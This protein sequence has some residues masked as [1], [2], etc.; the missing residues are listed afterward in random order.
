M[1]ESNIGVDVTEEGYVE[2]DWEDYLESK[3]MV[4]LAQVME[5][6]ATVRILN[7]LN[8]DYYDIKRRALEM[9]EDK[10]DE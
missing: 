10:T 2:I 8:T 1:V 9:L 4:S 7:N 5:G 3:R 6:I